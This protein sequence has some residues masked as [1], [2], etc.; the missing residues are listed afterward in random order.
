[1]AKGNGGF[2]GFNA[3]ADREAPAQELSAAH[4]NLLI[5]TALAWGFFLNYLLAKYVG[6]IIMNMIYTAPERY[7]AFMIGTLVG[8]FVLVLAGNIML[9]THEPGASF[10]GYTLIALPVGIVVTLATLGY[11]PTLVTRA[12]LMTAIVTLCMMIASTLFPAGFARM[13]SGLGIALL[14]VVIVELAGVFIFRMGFVMLDFVVVGIMCLYIGFDW[15]R[16]N[17]VPRTI[18]NAF[19]ISASLYLDIINIFLRLLRII[20]RSRRN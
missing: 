10:I 4:Y 13:G 20:S 16:A 12:A 18:G 15:V 8:Y 17:A 6:P 19:A 5:G 1:M 14:A 3:L 11:D 7:S 9:R 2:G